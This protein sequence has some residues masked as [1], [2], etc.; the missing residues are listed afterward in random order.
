MAI[1][2]TEA[3]VLRSQP[4]RTSSLIL[5][6][7][8]RSF[9]KVRGLVKG[10]RREGIPRPGAFEPFTLLEI[11]F[12]EKTRSDLHLISEATILESFDRLR[13]HL[14][15]LATAYYLV[16]L[17][18]RLT[19]PHDRHEPIFELLEFC[20]RSLP[21]L[22]LSFLVRFF[23]VRLLDEVGFLPH[24]THCL[25]CGEKNLEKVYFSARQGGIFC[26]RC[27]RRAPEAKTMRREVLKAMRDLAALKSARA[28]EVKPSLL[29]LTASIS[30]ETGEVIGDFLSERLGRRLTARR[31]LHQVQ[32]LQ[33]SRIP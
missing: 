29:E 28:E 2:K 12:Y 19:E 9:G 32:L 1:Q 8:S 31:F 14:E 10:V 22:P 24:L 27:R 26:A 5:T 7:F 13:T 23:E 21:L 15:V 11:V 18:D 16:E 33:S 25:V 6:T 20:F 3:F 30:K 17:V 4:F